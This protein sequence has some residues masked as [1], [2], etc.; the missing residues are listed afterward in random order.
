MP[1]Q[2]CMFVHLIP[3]CSYILTHAI[4]IHLLGKTLEFMHAL[5]ALPY[6][7]PMYEPLPMIRPP[8]MIR[9]LTKWS[10][11]FKTTR[12]VS[13]LGEVIKFYVHCHLGLLLDQNNKTIFL[14]HIFE[15]FAGDFINNSGSVKNFVMQYAPSDVVDYLKSNDVMLKYFDYNW[16]LNGQVKCNCTVW[17]RDIV[18]IDE[19]I[20]IDDFAEFCL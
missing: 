16:N 12:K 4:V 18:Y 13:I 5:C 6:H 8:L 2:A 17:I 11:S 3:A 14:S 9:W 15:W 1:R 19:C 10:S 7:A 20:L